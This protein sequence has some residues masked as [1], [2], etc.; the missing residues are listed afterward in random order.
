MISPLLSNLYLTEVDRML[1]RAKD[2]TRT[3]GRT[4]I[5]YARFAD[6]LVVLVDGRAEWDWLVRAVY[7]RL[8]EETVKL[9]VTMDEE[10]TRIAGGQAPQAFGLPWRAWWTLHDTARRSPFWALSSDE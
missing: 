5:E 9:D 10:K 8:V 1:E 2:R 3:G 4:H 7:R 6:D